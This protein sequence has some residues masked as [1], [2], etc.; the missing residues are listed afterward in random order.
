VAFRCFYGLKDWFVYF[1]FRH[2]FV[3]PFALLIGR[4][5]FLSKSLDRTKLSTYYCLMIPHY[6][7]FFNGGA[8]YAGLFSFPVMLERQVVQ[9]GG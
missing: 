3:F 8:V 2:A 1:L 5:K 7:P 9:E 4:L 6:F